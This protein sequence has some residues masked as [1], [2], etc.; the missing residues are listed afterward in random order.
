LGCRH[1]AGRANRAPGHA[2]N[3][4]RARTS[5]AGRRRAIS[6]RPHHSG[7]GAALDAGAAVCAVFITIARKV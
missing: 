2:T 4:V 1:Y 5:A 7:S 6:C 3:A